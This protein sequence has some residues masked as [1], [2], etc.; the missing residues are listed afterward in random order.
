MLSL[1]HWARRLLLSGLRPPL[2][3]R[4]RCTLLCNIDLLRLLLQPLPLLAVVPVVP[5]VVV[6][7]P[8]AVLVVAAPAV[9]AVLLHSER[10]THS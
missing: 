1:P 3:A 9:S 2:F 6:V 4:C 8:V 7:A 10:T 5:P